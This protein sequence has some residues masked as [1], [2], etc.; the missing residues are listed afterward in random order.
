MR[1]NRNAAF[2]DNK[3]GTS[4]TTDS[5]RAGVKGVEPF[6]EV[7]E[8]AILPMNYTPVPVR[9]KPDCDIIAQSANPVNHF[10]KKYF[11]SPLNC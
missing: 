6:S 8:T 10:L 1:K 3:K 7:L 4:L 2:S 5:H 9:C 11:I